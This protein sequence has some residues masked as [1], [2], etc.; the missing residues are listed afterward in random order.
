MSKDNAS[1]AVGWIFLASNILVIP[2]SILNGYKSDRY[3][4]W[5]NLL[6][7]NTVILIFLI[8]MIIPSQT[9]ATIYIGYTGS[10]TFFILLYT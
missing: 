7:N 6:I 4:V 9:I 10:L 1:S 8:I 2:V 5:I 3:K